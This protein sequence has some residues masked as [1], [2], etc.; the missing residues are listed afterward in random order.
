MAKAASSKGANR[1]A[2]ILAEARTVLVRDGYDALVLR[3]IADALDIKLGNLQYYFRTREDLVEAVVRKEAL[4]DLEDI[5]RICEAGGDDRGAFERLVDHIV[6]KWRGESG[7]IL[8][9]MGFLALHSTG[10]RSMY[11]EIYEAF[12]AALAGQI[13]C[14]MPSLPEHEADKRARLITALL[15]GASMQLQ[16]GDGAGFT[17]D[18]VDIAWA[19]ATRD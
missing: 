6:G 10:F 9:I 16:R 11:S 1:R 3:S 2:A 8:G 19:I 4:S 12:Y 15:D 14:L 5:R 7:R 18:V 13:R 17:R